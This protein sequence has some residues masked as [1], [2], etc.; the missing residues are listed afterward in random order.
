MKKQAASGDT[1]YY[2]SQNLMNELQL[3]LNAELM[4]LRIEYCQETIEGIRDQKLKPLQ[5]R[6]L[7]CTYVDHNCSSLTLSGEVRA[8]SRVLLSS[9]LRLR[10]LLTTTVRCMIT[11]N[12]QRRAVNRQRTGIV[13]SVKS[14]NRYLTSVTQDIA[15]E[16]VIHFGF[17]GR[18]T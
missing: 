7:A 6:Q 2:H 17:H 11:T 5:I 1:Y 10:L 18:S 13:Q 14:L 15:A 16:T 4:V 3:K 9:R 12:I 8:A